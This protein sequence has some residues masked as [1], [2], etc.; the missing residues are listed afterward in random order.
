VFH[1]SRLAP[2]RAGQSAVGWA[3][4]LALLSI[5]VTSGGQSAEEADQPAPTTWTSNKGLA[6]EAE[7]VR[8]TDEAV[9]LKMKRDGK[10][11]TVPLASLSIDSIYQ[12]VRL[13][14][15]EAFSKPVPKAEVKPEVTIELPELNLDVNELLK[16]PFANNTDIEKFL[17]ILERAPQEGNFLVG[18]HALP[19]KMQS[20]VEDLIVKG[21]EVL[22]PSTVK[23][24]QM[25]LND[26]DTVLQDKQ[27]FIKGLPQVQAN[28]LVVE[29]MDQNL[30]LL[31]NFVAGLAKDEHWQPSNFQKGSVP[32][33][34]ASLNVDLAPATLA[35]LE[36]VKSSLPEGMALPIG[37]S[38][39][40]IVSQKADSA[41]VEVTLPGRPP[42]K[43]TF[44]KVGNIWIN[45]EQMNQLRVNL[46][47]AKEKLAAGA[48]QEV[49][50]LRSSLSG[51]IAA[52]GG[53]ARANTQAEFD[54]AVALLQTIGGGLN[55]SLGLN[56]A[57]TAQPGSGP[58]R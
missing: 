32:R 36:S 6:V 9:V 4:T 12:A 10:E 57:G 46:D 24:M 58:G 8:M 52:V 39:F 37:N 21:Y 49:G 26:L 48:T 18:W 54:E 50:L 3:L 13:A 20:D 33:W 19:P 40:N 44:Q 43:A 5:P 42:E 17:Q 53:L 31:A 14:N 15:P 11:A 38:T 2:R 23:Q 55:Q 1:L 28:P 56:A 30:P 41:E 47:S 45:V 27:Q 29:Q 25:L 7:F 34:L 16:S 35:A 22:G 51:I